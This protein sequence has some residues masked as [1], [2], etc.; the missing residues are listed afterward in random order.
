MKLSLYSIEQEYLNI[1]ESI[2]DA[3]GE[4]TEEQETALSIN[5]EQL[6]TKGVCYGFIVKQMEGE[7]DLIDAEIKRLTALKKTRSNTID[8]LKANLSTAMQV[9]DIEELK[10]PLIKINFRKSESVEV[11]ANL[12]TEYTKTVTTVT[13][14]KV[15]IKEAIKA[16]LTVQGARLVTNQNIQIK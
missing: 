10:T 1:V 5:K 11:D 15:A 6:Q 14:D 8:R 7:I 2:V 13:P 3:G 12:D 16:G 9:F 4:I